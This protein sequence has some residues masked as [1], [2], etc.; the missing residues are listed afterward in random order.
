MKFEKDE[1]LFT[2]RLKSIG[3]AIKGAIKLI[4]TEHSVM[5]QSSLAII[6]TIAGF[7]MDGDLDNCARQTDKEIFLAEVKKLALQRN[8]SIRT[9]MRWCYLRSDSPEM[10]ERLR[11]WLSEEYSD[12]SKLMSLPE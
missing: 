11:A 6:M 8:A 4:T 3:F 9:V 12:R 1:T 7:N 5:V 10:A 2:G